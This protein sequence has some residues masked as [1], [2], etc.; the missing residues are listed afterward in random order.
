MSAAAG[1]LIKSEMRAARR[2][3]GGWA[4]ISGKWIAPSAVTGRTTRSS[5]NRAACISPNCSH[6]LRRLPPVPQ[7]PRQSPEWV[8]G[9]LSLQP[10]SRQPS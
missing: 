2:S 8:L 10:C 4:G 7:A 1:A 5:A 3:H 9:Q 6:V